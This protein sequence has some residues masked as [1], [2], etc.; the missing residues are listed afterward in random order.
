M[1]EAPPFW[2]KPSGW[3]STV[4]APF[5]WIYGTIARY[6]MD[7]APRLKVA[8]AVICVGNPTVGGSGKTPVALALGKTAIAMG[9]RPGFLSRGYG[10]SV[11]GPHL[12]DPDHDMARLVGDEPL[13]LAR[14]A[15]TVV[16]ANRAEAAQKLI[17]L[18]VN[19]IIMDDGFQSA[20]VHFD[21]ALLVVDARRGIGNGAIIPAGPLRAPLTDQLRHSDALVVVGAGSAADGVIRRAARAGKPV[22]TAKLL[23]DAA[24]GIAG[25]RIVAFAG[26]GDPEK[27]F[28]TVREMGAELVAAR[29]FGDHHPYG[30]A[31]LRELDTLAKSLKAR[32]VTT[33]KDA[34]RMKGTSKTA[35]GMANTLE[36]VGVEIVFAD[37]ALLE[38]R[39]RQAI[40]RFNTRAVR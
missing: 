7:H 22:H 19:L 6:R 28:A 21:E 33:A 34:V 25:A 15:P 30:E 2:W 38:N 31:E 29:A 1:S 8:A 27:F 36:I 12:V 40:A 17:Q 3:Q 10:G 13:L 5:A 20:K 23:P 18:G 26:I 11:T 9:L 16:G 24:I 4:L 32:L 14:Q 35:S 37:S 39:I